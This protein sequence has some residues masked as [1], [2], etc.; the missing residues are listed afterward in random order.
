MISTAY[1]SSRRASGYAQDTKKA[2]STP[3][4]ARFR[5]PVVLLPAQGNDGLTYT[6][7]KTQIFGPGDVLDLGLGSGS[8][9]HIM[10]KSLCRPGIEVLLCPLEQPASGGG[11]ATGS[12][13]PSIPVGIT[14]SQTHSIFVNNMYG[15]SFSTVVGDTVAT[16]CDS[17]VACINANVDL[18]ITS[19][20][21][22]TSAGVN[23]KWEGTTGNAI[24]IEIVSPVDTEV[25]FA[26]T[27]PTGG[28]GLPSVTAALAQVGSQWVT[29]IANGAC[30]YT[31]TADAVMLAEYATFG[32]ARRDPE[33]HKP[34]VVFTGTNEATVGTVTAVTDAR[35]TDRTNCIIPNGG[36]HDLPF[37][38]AAEAVR[39]IAI[40]DAADPAMAYN[41]KKLAGLTAPLSNLE[42][43]SDMRQ[44][45]V[46]AG[47]STVEI[48]DGEVY[49]SDVVTCYHPSTDTDRIFAYVCDIA[50]HSCITNELDL[51]VN[52][53]EFVGHPVVPDGQ[54][55]S[56][57]NAI[58]M[59]AIKGAVD[60]M[61]DRLSDAAIVV[62]P[63]EIK[64][65]TQL[66]FIEGNPGRTNVL[67]AA[68]IS[69]NNKI[70]S[71]TVAIVRK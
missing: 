6:T 40:Q 63:D 16:I 39:E 69:S 62:Y 24:Y 47:C 15:G 37:V 4:K 28:T 13:T 58:K 52:A 50:K 18:T 53:S 68:P 25:S 2:P 46:T 41:R 55:T 48:V 17:I 19:T 30:D 9:A 22:T 21:D 54:A 32:E 49:L 5:P 44:A 11:K 12:I 29:H 14:K 33:V 51:T 71:V 8:P 1:P 27:Q 38:I 57:P 26:I 60:S 67:Y 65:N 36:S 43:N 31:G 35:T 64:E 56:N 20:D 45:A 59:K 70:I 10:A 66:E 34:L 42:W 7:T 61:T 3:T 23:A